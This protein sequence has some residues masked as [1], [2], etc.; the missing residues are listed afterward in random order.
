VGRLALFFRTL[1]GR[2]VGRWDPEARR[3]AA[4]DDRYVEPLARAF[5]VARKQAAPDL[6]TLPLPT[7]KEGR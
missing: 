2:R 3:W 5:A 4:L 7:P 6:L 1:D